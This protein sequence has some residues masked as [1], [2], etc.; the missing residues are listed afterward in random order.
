MRTRRRTALA[1]L[2]IVSLV[3]AAVAALPSGA[4]TPGPG[5]FKIR[6]RIAKLQMDVAGYVE[7]K[8]LHDTTSDCF[9]GER[10][11]QTHEYAFETGDYVNVSVKNVSAPGLDS[12]VTS[13][14]S[15]A[16]GSAKVTAGISDYRSTNYCKDAPK[17]LQGPPACKTNAGKLRVGLTP[18]AVPEEV[19]GPASLQ[20]RPLNV[21]ISRQGGGQHA[22]TCLGA[23]ADSFNSK[24]DMS[25]ALLTTSLAPGPSVSL[26][27]KLDAIDI[28][29]LRRKARVKRVIVA[30]GPCSKVNYTVQAPPGS[31]PPGPT[32]NA[33]GDCFI[34]AKI[35]VTIRA[36][37]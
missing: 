24:L 4:A 21:A 17:K 20:G 36:R 1:L 15:K 3:V 27:A 29:S 34:R 30:S 8:E 19:D 10:W 32:L 26:P 33:D 11:I 14:L 23:A 7:A 13:R 37:G 12:V 5:S 28:F 25:V 16:V 2:I 18:G 22:A 35:V 6:T 31:S 9:P